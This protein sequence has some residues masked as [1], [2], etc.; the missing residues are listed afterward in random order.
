MSIR[1]VRFNMNEL[2]KL[3]AKA[4][5][6]S[7]TQCVHV[8]G[9][10]PNPNAGRVYYT[11]ASEVA[12]MDFV[13]NTLGIPVPKVLAWSSK[14]KKNLVGAEYIIM[15]KVLGVVKVIAGYQ[16]S[17][18]EPRFTVGP[19]TGRTF[20]DDGRVALD[21]DRGP[22]VGMRE[23]RSVQEISELSQSPILLHGPMKYLLLINKLIS[24]IFLF[25]S[26]LYVENIFINLESLLQV[27][28]TI[29]YLL[30]TDLNL[31]VLPENFILYRKLIYT[32]N[33][34]LYKAIKFRETTT[35][36]LDLEEEWLSLPGVHAQDVSGAI[37]GMDIMREFKQLLG[38][39]W[40]EKG[41]VRHDQYG[42]MIDGLAQF[43][44][45]WVAW[46]KA[47]PFDD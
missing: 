15:E 23:I 5:G 40:P 16:K 11:T 20:L 19:S 31:P 24:S 39:D 14:A 2:V 21:L 38:E 35:R 30:I 3:A 12:T 45:E 26:D 6:Y 4:V 18:M 34:R 29:D 22:S 27:F 42:R 32:I 28:S 47:W 1:Y 9:K 44:D 7:N 13:R 46:N 17:W 25:Y 37:R 36:V 10:V 41:V 33:E 8:V 43:E